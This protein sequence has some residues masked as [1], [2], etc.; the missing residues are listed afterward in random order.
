MA[1]TTTPINFEFDKNVGLQDGVILY[2]EASDNFC[3]RISDLDNY[4]LQVL[5]SAQGVLGPFP[6]ASKAL[7][8]D[9]LTFVNP[10]NN[11]TLFESFRYKIKKVGLKPEPAVINIWDN[12]VYWDGTN[13]RRRTDDGILS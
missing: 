10:Y 4:E 12:S 6:V 13:V 9:P 3:L 7:I 5:E 1:I 2:T 11:L 8:D